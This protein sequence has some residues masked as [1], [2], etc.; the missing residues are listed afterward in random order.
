MEYELISNIGN[1][2]DNVY[3]YSS[4]DGAR[5]TVAK[6]NNDKEMSISFRTILNIG[7][8][9]DLQHQ[10]A[11]L[12]KEANDLISSRLRTIKAEFKSLSGRGLITK[13]I[14]SNDSFETLT[15]S[16]YSPFRK[17]KYTCSYTYEVK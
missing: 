12:K 14:S 9:S 6:L 16:P 13:K 15:V 17:I 3:N 11:F 5:K 1:A 10:T 4:E 8:D 2:I 7:R